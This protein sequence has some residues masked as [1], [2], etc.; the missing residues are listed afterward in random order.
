MAICSGAERGQLPGLLLAGLVSSMTGEQ[1]RSFVLESQMAEKASSGTASICAQRM[2]TKGRSSPRELLGTGT[3]LGPAP[4]RFPAKGAGRDC[5]GG[6]L[7][8]PPARERRRKEGRERRDGR[9]SSAV[10]NLQGHLVPLHD[11]FKA[12]LKFKHGSKYIVQMLL[13]H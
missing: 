13:G 4:Q 1:S 10:R 12:D 8:L 5:G 11:Q 7:Q 6:P 3:A 2:A 9:Y